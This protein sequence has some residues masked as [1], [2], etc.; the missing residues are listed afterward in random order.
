MGEATVI[1]GEGAVA[2][3]QGA[4]AVGEQGITVADDGE[5]NRG[6]WD[7]DGVIYRDDED[8]HVYDDTEAWQVAAGVAAG[9]VIGT[10]LASPPAEA[11]TVTVAST[12]Y[13]YSDNAFYMP[14]MQGTE[15]V[16]QVVPAPVGAVPTLPLGCRHRMSTA[17]PTRS[18]AGPPTCRYRTGIRSSP[19]RHREGARPSFQRLGRT[20]VGEGCRPPSPTPGRTLMSAFVAAPA[21]RGPAGRSRRAS[22]PRH[23]LKRSRPGRGRLRDVLLDRP[24]SQ[25]AIA[26]LGFRS[27]AQRGDGDPQ[28]SPGSR[29]IPWCFRAAGGSSDWRARS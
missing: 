17:W 21:S 15:V 18:A 5:I 7:D 22:D 27:R 6:E 12:S 4:V 2:G 29:S 19:S 14:V 20:S 9:V 11:T 10:M 3:E 13:Y 25:P 24:R 16:Y 26:R 1:Q 28:I 23:K 8:F